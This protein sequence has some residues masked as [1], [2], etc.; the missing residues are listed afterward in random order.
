MTKATA[1]PTV[2]TINHKVYNFAER[3]EA[4]GLLANLVHGIKPYSRKHIAELL[5]EIRKC[6]VEN[7]VRISSVDLSYLQRFESE[8]ALSSVK[9]VMI[10]FIAFA[11]GKFIRV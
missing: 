5:S 11:K 4:G 2:N 7:K 1:H 10:D 8:F 6:L 9:K 3:F